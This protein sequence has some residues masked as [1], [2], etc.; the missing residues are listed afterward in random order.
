MVTFRR[1][2][3]AGR[4]T[5]VVEDVGQRDGQAGEQWRAEGVGSG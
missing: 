3:F 5:A 1:L 2:F 4:T